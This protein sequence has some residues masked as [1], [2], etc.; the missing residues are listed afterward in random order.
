M[1]FAAADFALPHQFVNLK[2]EAGVVGAQ[3]VIIIQRTPVQ[4]SDMQKF[5]STLFV[6]ALF[7]AVAWGGWFPR[8][9]VVTLLP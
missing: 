8:N 3:R 5:L 6:I 1:T 2:A 4:I 7:V 9:F